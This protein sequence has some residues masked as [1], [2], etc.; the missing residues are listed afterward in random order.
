[1]GGYRYDDALFVKLYKQGKSIPKLSEIF[2]RSEGSIERKLVRMGLKTTKPL[3]PRWPKEDQKRLSDLSKECTLTEIIPHFP[4]RTVNAIKCQYTKLKCKPAFR[5]HRMGMK[6]R[7]WTKSEIEKLKYLIAEYSAE[8][9]A[10]ILGRTLQSVY[11]KCYQNGIRINDTFYKVKDI[12]KVLGIDTNTVNN[13]AKKLKIIFGSSYSR[14][15]DITDISR[16]ARSIIDSPR[17][18]PRVSM[19]HLHKI[20]KMDATDLQERIENAGKVA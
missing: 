19:L 10:K 3:N 13:H 17:S 16:I 12:A 18:S 20:A 1:M 9:T 5:F 14:I 15:Q 4:D 2:K 11:V 6:C 8:K 7:Y